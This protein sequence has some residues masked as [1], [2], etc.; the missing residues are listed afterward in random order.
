MDKTTRQQI[1]VARWVNAGYKGILDYVMR[2]GKTYTAMI[3]I[4]EVLSKVQNATVLVI[5]PSVI[6]N[7]QWVKTIK[8]LGLDTNKISTTTVNNA[9]N[10]CNHAPDKL[11]VSLLIVDECH[12]FTTLNRSELINGTLIEYDYI[13]MLTGTLPSGEDLKTLTRIAPVVDV[14][15]ESEALANDWITNLIEYNV[16]LKLSDDDKLSYTKW[17]IPIRET[18]KV[19]NGSD[20]LFGPIFKNSYEVINSCITGKNYIH[21]GISYYI[22]ANVIRE[23]LAIKMGWHKDIDITTKYGADR[24]KYWNPD[25]I[26]DRAKDFMSCVRKRNEVLINNDTK[27]EAVQ[28]ILKL[29]F[30]VTICFNESTDFAD[31]ISTVINKA[32]P[33]APAICYHSNIESKELVDLN[34]VPILYKSG[35]KKGQPKKFGKTALRALAIEGIT[36]GVYKLLCTARALDEGLDIPNIELVITTGGTTN[37]TQY[38]QRKSR[39]RTV[40]IYNKTKVTKIINLYFEDF[41]ITSDEIGLREYMVQSRDKQ[42]LIL[43]Q[44]G[45][46][47]VIWLSGLEDLGKIFAK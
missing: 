24:D 17:S 26:H 28:Y 22:S 15:T 43:R 11:K 20:K 30:P 23:T 25:A 31:T 33:G 27:L 46:T 19:F 16:P 45:N 3:A 1:G 7:N 2:F 41:K 40:D 4:K 34:G 32:Y 37:P 9:I 6:I 13:L 10:Y 35:D 42:K 8:D 21:E 5:T 18:L 47:N 39:G 29:W 12:K 14:I 38:K 44:E 36:N